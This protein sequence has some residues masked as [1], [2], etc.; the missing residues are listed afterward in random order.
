ME[1]ELALFV[2]KARTR[3]TNYESLLLLDCDC[4][5]LDSVTDG[6]RKAGTETCGT[7]SLRSLGLG[8]ATMRSLVV[9]REICRFTERRICLMIAVSNLYGRVRR[10]VSSPLLD[11]RILTHG[12]ARLPVDYLFCA[13]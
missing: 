1:G 9:W 8:E 6:Q 4:R 5:V 13:K 12:K 2:Q 7:G 10:Q 11:K 3:I